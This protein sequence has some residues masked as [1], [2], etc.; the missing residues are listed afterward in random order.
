MDLVNEAEGDPEMLTF[1]RRVLNKMSESVG[2][3]RRNVPI[4]PQPAGFSGIGT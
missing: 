2:A 3:L 1:V 4:L